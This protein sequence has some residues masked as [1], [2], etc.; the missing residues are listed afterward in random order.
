MTRRQLQRLRA[1]ADEQYESMRGS[2][3]YRRCDFLLYVLTVVV[4]ALAVRAFLVEPI[5]VDG[6]SMTP[7][8]VDG[9]HMLVEKLSFWTR[10]PARGEIIICFYPG[11]TESCVKRVIGLPGETVSV[12]DGRVFIDGD[13][14]DESY[15]WNDMIYG[16]TEPVLVGNRQVFVMGDNRNGSKDSRNPSVGCISSENIVG[17]VVAVIWPV[18]NFV[19]LTGRA[20]AA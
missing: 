16:D 4:F 15:Y 20:Y 3:F 13:P 6:S 12:K 19:K 7:T 18:S 17:R 9:E 8:L 2:R 5:R 11:Y 10:E 14:L 1:E